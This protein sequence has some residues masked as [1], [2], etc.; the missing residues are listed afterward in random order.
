[1]W[2]SLRAVFHSLAIEVEGQSHVQKK[3][4]C[5][6]PTPNPAMT[7]HQNS[8]PGGLRKRSPTQLI[9]LPTSLWV[10]K[11]SQPFLLCCTQ[12]S[13]DLKQLLHQPGSCWYGWRDIA[14]HLLINFHPAFS[15]CLRINLISLMKAIRIKKLDGYLWSTQFFQAPAAKALL[16]LSLRHFPLLGIIL[17]F[18]Q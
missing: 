18:I 3:V 15:S 14:E 12:G 4:L 1:M 9:N 10:G 17:Q 6:R 11:T 7:Q 8:S 2:N 13:M 16:R 5:E